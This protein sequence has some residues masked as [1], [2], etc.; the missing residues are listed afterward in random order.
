MRQAT[1]L[2][3]LLKKTAYCLV[4]QDEIFSRQGKLVQINSEKSVGGKRRGRIICW[5]LSILFLLNQNWP[6]KVAATECFQFMS[7][8]RSHAPQLHF[9]PK[10]VGGTTVLTDT[11]FIISPSLAYLSKLDALFIVQLCKE[12]VPNNQ[13]E[14]VYCL[15]TFYPFCSFPLYYL[16]SIPGLGRS[17]REW[18]GYPL[19]YS[20][21]ENSMDSIVHGVTKKSQTQPSDFPFPILSV[22]TGVCIIEVGDGTK[23]TDHCSFL[24]PFP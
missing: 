23:V 17:P 11:C 10:A 14:F 4:V 7:C 9:S 20:G 1:R 12:K 15:H 21:L 16:G 19:Q 3:T 22:L 13:R 5:I 18:T 6:H 2:A 24:I 8:R